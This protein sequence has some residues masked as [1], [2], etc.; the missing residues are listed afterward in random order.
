MLI[1][2]PPRA[3]AAI[4]V[5]AVLLVDDLPESLR[6]MQQQLDRADVVILTARSGQ[7][8]L[9]ILVDNEVAVAL[10]DVQMPGMDGFELAR[11]MREHPSMRAVPVVFVTAS[12]P[13]AETVRRGYDVGGVDFLFKPVD[14]RVLIGKVDVFVQ[15]WRQ[16]RQL[17]AQVDALRLSAIAFETHEAIVL[18]DAAARIVKVNRAFEEITG[19]AEADVLGRNPSLLQS[20]RQSKA[21]YRGIW[22]SLKR[23]GRWEGELW[24][25]TRDGTEYCEWKRITTVRG[26][27]GRIT[28]YVGIGMDITQQKAAQEEV[29]RMH[30]TLERRVEE[31]TAALQAANAELAAFSYSVSHDLK[32]P[33]RA[34]DGFTQLLLTEDDEHLSDSGRTYLQ[35]IRGATSRMSALIEGLLTLSNIGRSALKRDWFDLSLVAHEVIAAR[36]AVE[37]ARHVDVAVQPGL[38]AFGDAALVRV[39]L[40]NLVGN[41]LKYTIDCEPARLAIA[42]TELGGVPGFE[43]RDNGIGFDMQYADKLFTP[44]QRLHSDSRYPGTG[45]GLATVARIVQRHGGEVVAEGAPGDGAAIR[46]TLGRA[47]PAGVAP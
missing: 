21:F 19:Y 45:I 10:V 16:R 47:C 31:R 12:G 36:L 28:H 5:P 39:L 11:R 44:F 4:A 14:P 6:S 41:A 17:A 20:G 26:P 15:L 35:R 22:H 23:T 2:S 43:V 42:A 9:D 7:E 1:A 37:P 33:V 29:R 40:D 8:A 38:R 18:T 34:I 32:A 3:D 46:F 13:R 24:N 27:S 25:R 30:A